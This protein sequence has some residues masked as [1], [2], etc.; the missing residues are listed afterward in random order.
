M[1]DNNLK[2]SEVNS[3]VG[4]TRAHTRP[5]RNNT[6]HTQPITLTPH[7]QLIDLERKVQRLVAATGAYVHIPWRKEVPS[8]K[9]Y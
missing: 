6:A 1:N 3:A 2:H 4:T 5:V 9:E 7:G 8:S